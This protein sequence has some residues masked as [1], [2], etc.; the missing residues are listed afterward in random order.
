MRAA[1][2]CVIRLSGIGGDEWAELS[3]GEPGIT[4]PTIK[5]LLGMIYNNE[6][7]RS[8]GLVELTE[9]RDFRLDG[10]TESRFFQFLGCRLPAEALF[11]PGIALHVVAVA[12]PEAGP[13]ALHK[14]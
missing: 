6:S 10:S 1:V 12:L 7:A 5:R 8:F 14:F 3:R 2:V 13:I 9:K 11:E 4:C